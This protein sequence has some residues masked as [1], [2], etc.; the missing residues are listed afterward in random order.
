MDAERDMD[1]AD[2]MAEDI[3]GAGAA[4]PG[5]DAEGGNPISELQS[6]ILEL[7]RRHDQVM[8]ALSN[9]T[10]VHTRSYVYIPREK[11]IVPFSGDL[12][13]DCQNVDEFIEEL[14]RVIRVRGLNSEDQ[15]DFI[16]SHLRGS[17]LDEVKLCMGGEDK[18][19]EDMFSYLRAA[20]REKRSTSQLLHTFYARKQLDSEDFRDFSHALSLMLNAALQQAPQCVP[21]VQRALRD[22]FIEGV[23]DLA[24]RRE[25]RKVVRERPDATLFEVREE[26]LLWCSEERPRSTNVARNRNLVSVKESAENAQMTATVTNDLTLALQDVIKVITQQG[27]A[28]GELTNAV[29]DLT[30]QRSDSALEKSNKPKFKPRYTRGGQPICLRCESVGHIARHCTGQRSQENPVPTTSESLIAGNGAP[31]LRRAEQ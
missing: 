17:A 13:K 25:L 12:G 16:L 3:E 6:Q 15:V 5:V 27:K 30:I 24:L 23:R 11:Q 26:A 22:Q 2:A 4:A 21:N 7:G 31:P 29:R 8:S 28:I 9:M 10:N 18:S 1:N 14:E 19:A 20:F